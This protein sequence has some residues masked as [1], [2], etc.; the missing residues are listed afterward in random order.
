[1]SPV[2]A[3]ALARAE[4]ADAGLAVEGDLASVLTADGVASPSALVACDVA[5]PHRVSKTRGRLFPWPGC[6]GHSAQRGEGHRR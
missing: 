6:F 1:M 3:A 5:P 2:L 4:A